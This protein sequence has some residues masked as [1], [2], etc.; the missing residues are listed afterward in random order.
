MTEGDRAFFLEIA[1]SGLWPE[2][3]SR[4]FF[5]VSKGE[6]TAFENWRTVQKNNYQYAVGQGAGDWVKIVLGNYLACHVAWD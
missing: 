3:G 2:V 1:C 4:S 5:N 6:E